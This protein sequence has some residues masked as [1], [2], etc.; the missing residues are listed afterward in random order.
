MVLIRDDRTVLRPFRA[1]ELDQW[2]AA[3][4]ESADDRTVSPMGPPNRQRVAERIERSG[5]FHEGMLDLAIEVDGRLIGEIG[6]YEEPGRQ[7]RPGLFFLSIGLFRPQDRHRGF[8]TEAVRLLCD[9]LVRE[10]GANRI[11]SGTADTNVAMRRVF[12]KLGFRFEGTET[13][14]EVEWARYSLTPATT[15]NNSAP[16]DRAQ[17]SHLSRGPSTKPP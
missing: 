13:A 1:D 6:T 16:S 8:G 17:A 10:A 7:I 3:R 15:A 4:L 14:W 9:W 2:F 5:T 11:E 12:E